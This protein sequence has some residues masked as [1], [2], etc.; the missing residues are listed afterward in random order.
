MD[1]MVQ[2]GIILEK[3]GDRGP[4]GIPCRIIFQS[5]SEISNPGTQLLLL[6]RNKRRYRVA[7]HVKD[8]KLS[9]LRSELQEAGLTE[10]LIPAEQKEL[11][12]GLAISL[13]VFTAILSGLTWL[14]G[15]I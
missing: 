14:A 12:C 10:D 4:F 5:C 11:V 8:H 1:A 3:C 2:I 6:R 15:F 9:V 13:M 7:T